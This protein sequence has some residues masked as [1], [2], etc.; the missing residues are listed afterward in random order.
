LQF[1]YGFEVEFT[2]K[3]LWQNWVGLVPELKPESILKAQESLRKKINELCLLNCDPGSQKSEL[4][5]LTWYF[6]E[7][8]GLHDSFVKA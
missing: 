1:T 3:D 5:R 6:F 8:S 4:G 2:H 7:T